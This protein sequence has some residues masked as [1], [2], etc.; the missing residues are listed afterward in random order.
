MID[1]IYNLINETWDNRDS[2]EPNE[3]TRER[4]SA[5]QLYKL[6][7][8]KIGCKVCGQGSCMGIASKLILGTSRLSQSTLMKEAEYAPNY[9]SLEA[10]LQLLGYETD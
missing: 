3:E 1:H 7:P 9:V 6:L 5:I 2:I 4:P 8:K 10:H